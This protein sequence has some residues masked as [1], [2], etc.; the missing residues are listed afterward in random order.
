MKLEKREI[1]L[2]EQDSL[3]DVLFMEKSL[4]YEYVEGLA[5]VYRRE[6]REALLGFFKAVAEDLFLI[7]DLL[8]KLKSEA[9][10]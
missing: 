10:N 2:N 9:V 5:K 8:E 1:M 7:N 4:L 3:S 6:S